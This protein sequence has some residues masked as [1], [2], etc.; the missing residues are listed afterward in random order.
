VNQAPSAPAATTA[1]S[2]DDRALAAVSHLSFLVGFWLAAPIAIYVIKRKESRFVAFSA[3]Q[4]LLL[5][6]LFCA[7][8]AGFGVLFVVVGALAGSVAHQ[9]GAALVVLPILGVLGA[10]VGCGVLLALHLIAAYRAWQGTSISL[11][12]VGSLAN[13]IMRADEGAAKV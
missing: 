5:Q 12:I 13:A 7:G 10:L 1:F 9:A 3:L 4:A 6:L 8:F 11:P 2:Q